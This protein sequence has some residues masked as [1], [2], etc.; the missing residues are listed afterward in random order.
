MNSQLRNLKIQNLLEE[1]E[2]LEADLEELIRLRADNCHHDTHRIWDD[3]WFA[4]CIKCGAS[5][6]ANAFFK[7]EDIPYDELIAIRLKLTG[8]VNLHGDYK[9]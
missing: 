4:V 6:C 9:L 8:P 5:Q 3:G 1:H 2:I 7:P